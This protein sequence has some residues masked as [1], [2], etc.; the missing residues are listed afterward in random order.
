M[1]AWANLFSRASSLIKRPAV[2]L[3]GIFTA[4]VATYVTSLLTPVGPWLS[5]R[6]REKVCEYREYRQKA[7][8]DESQFTILVSPLAHDPDGSHTEKVMR[9]FFPPNGFHA[10]RICESLN[11]DFSKDTQ[12][13]LNEALQRARDL[14]KT[15]H[16]DLLLF[17]DVR[18]PDDAVVIY[19]M[20]EHGGCELRPKPTII[21]HGDLPDDFKTEE[22]EKLI[23]VSL[24]ELESACSNQESID[25]PAF[26]KRMNKMGNFL[27]DLPLNKAEYESIDYH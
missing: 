24:Q 11:F 9:A 25:W 1:S 17:G 15:K 12:A 10:V 23:A 21:E 22:K 16:A 5:E 3:G 13:A 7:I 18:K 4:A 8:A 2:W 20:N 14:I 27:K 19:A 26:A 6:A